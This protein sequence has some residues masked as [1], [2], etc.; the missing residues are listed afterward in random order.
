MEA[1]VTAPS[2]VW[3]LGDYRRYAKEMVWSVGPELV[4]ACGIGSGQRV[5]DV[6]AGTGNV[7]IRAAEAGA[8]VIASDRDA[9]E[10]G[11]RRAR[12]AR[13][14]RRGGMGRRGRAGRFRSGTA[15]STS[16]PRRSARC[17]RPTTRRQR[18]SC[19][20]SA[21]PAARSGWRT[22]R[23]TGGVGEFFGVFAPYLPAPPPDAPPPLL[24][25]RRGA[26]PDALRRPRQRRSS[27]S[28]RWLI[29]RSSGGPREY[30]DFYRETFGP[31]VAAY[32]RRRPCRAA[33]LD[34]A[35]LRRSRRARNRG[36]PERPVGVPLRV[37][38]R[39]G[40]KG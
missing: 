33:D 29:E 16:S 26:R 19:C 13:A 17:S 23:P 24:V 28:R 38:A 7:A 36:E 32:S 21:G 10:P 14:R 18:T 5:L 4:A 20:A 34:A 31:A 35:F 30:C 25:G 11:G 40:R 6:A 2:T 12:G 1:Q 27:W 9:G 37:P 3:A 22:S 15:S 8:D 39:G